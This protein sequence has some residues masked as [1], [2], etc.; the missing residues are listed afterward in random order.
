MIIIIHHCSAAG[1]QG[2][3]ARGNDRSIH[4]SIRHQA[5]GIFVRMLLKLVLLL[6]PMKGQ[7]YGLVL[8]A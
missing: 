5:S 8:V 7:D 4:S 1:R 6:Y 2:A 3:R